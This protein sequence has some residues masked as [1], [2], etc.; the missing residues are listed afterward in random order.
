MSKTNIYRYFRI[1]EEGVGG[2]N[3]DIYFSVSKDWI[4]NN[5]ISEIEVWKYGYAPI[6]KGEGQM[7]RNWFKLETNFVNETL[8]EF[9]YKFNVTGFSY[10]AVVGIPVETEVIK[11]N[12]NTTTVIGGIE[13]CGNGVCE[14]GEN[15]P[16]DCGEDG[17]WG[18]VLMAFVEQTRK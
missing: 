7:G 4:Q 2:G 11:N 17:N 14:A 10:F 16:E 18:I 15:C 13:S 1:D 8:D 3:F 5:S 12:T 6:K 9:M